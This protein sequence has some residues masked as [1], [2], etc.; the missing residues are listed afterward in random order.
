MLVPRSQRDLQD[1]FREIS[2]LKEAGTEVRMAEG[3]VRVEREFGSV[4]GL[5]DEIGVVA[6]DDKDTVRTMTLHIDAGP[7]TLL[8]DLRWMP[9][10]AE[11]RSSAEAARYQKS[12]IRVQ[13]E[14]RVVET[15][16]RLVCGGIWI[17]PPA[18]PSNEDQAWLCQLASGS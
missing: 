16:G 13:F 7:S 6:R 9:V 17:F 5:L 8:L 2:G 1:L 4:V 12:V 3:G 10:V 15:D 18:C 14:G 11:G